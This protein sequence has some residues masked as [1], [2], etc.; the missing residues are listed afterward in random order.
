MTSNLSNYMNQ[1]AGYQEDFEYDVTLL[2]HAIWV[3]YGYIFVV[4]FVFF[5]VIKFLFGS[6]DGADASPS[7]TPSYIDLVSLYGYSLVP[8]FFGTLLCGILPFNPV[9]WIVLLGSTLVSL[10]FVLRN[11]VTFVMGSASFHQAVPQQDETDLEDEAESPRTTM[12]YVQRAKGGPV[13]GSIMGVHVIFCLILKL[14]F[15]HP[16]ATST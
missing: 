6:T 5:V 4:P 3:L 2:L 9:Q 15:Y 8:F 10:I 16:Y 14:G 13:L 1:P 12:I 7:N 11:L